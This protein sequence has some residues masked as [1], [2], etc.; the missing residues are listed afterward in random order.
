MHKEP[1]LRLALW[2]NYIVL[3]K[4]S[5]SELLQFSKQRNEEYIVHQQ[6]AVTLLGLH[7]LEV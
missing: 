2:V 1:D 4:N 3:Y 7:Y 6:I 5:A